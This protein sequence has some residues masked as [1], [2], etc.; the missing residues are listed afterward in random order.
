MVTKGRKTGF[1]IIELLTVM[2]IIALLMALL[3]PAL[4]RVRRYAK[5]VKQKGQFHSIE[6]GLEMYRADFGEYPESNGP[7]SNSFLDGNGEP[8]CG[9]MRLAEALVGQDG[10]GFHPDSRFVYDDIDPLL[11]LGELYPNS[12]ILGNPPVPPTT[13]YLENLRER[14][15]LYI[16]PDTELVT[17]QDLYAPADMGVFSASAQDPNGVAMIADSF[18][19]AINRRTGKKVGMPVLYYKADTSKMR[20]SQDPILIDGHQN[21]YDIFDNLDLVNL[22][23]PWYSL[24]A[25]PMSDSALSTQT[26]GTPDRTIFIGNTDNKKSVI[27]KPYNPDSYILISA[28]FDGE[29]GTRDDVFNFED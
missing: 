2:S 9:A 4:N 22:E 16:S 23:I 1:T 15:Q 19:R 14:K 6:I 10:Q 21:I 13:N 17:L 18:P 26:G 12:G 29:Y 8:Y 3:V 24:K 25:H 27:E 11:P 28:G 20:Y 7:A 5:V